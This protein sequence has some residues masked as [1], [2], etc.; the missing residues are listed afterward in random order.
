MAF[1]SHLANTI[2]KAGNNHR[3]YVVNNDSSS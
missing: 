1:D 2:I 3:T